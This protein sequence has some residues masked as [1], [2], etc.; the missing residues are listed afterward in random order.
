MPFYYPVSR[1]KWSAVVSDFHDALIVNKAS[2][3]TA[4]GNVSRVK[5]GS[6]DRH[7]VTREPRR[8]GQ[9]KEELIV[10][11]HWR[12]TLSPALS[13]REQVQPRA[14]DQMVPLHTIRLLLPFNCLN[15]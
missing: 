12:Q 1:T 3:K 13:E 5:G 8:P 14:L 11:T 15:I 2:Y 6:L 9:N 7:R 10:E 4:I